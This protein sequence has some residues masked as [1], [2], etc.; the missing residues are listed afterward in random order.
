MEEKK[1][2]ILLVEDNPMDAELNVY[3]LNKFGYNFNSKVVDTKSAYL[4]AIATFEPDIILS[5]YSMPR[6]DGMTSLLIRN[7]TCPFV[8]FIVV[9]GSINEETAVICI[10]A[11]AN[12]YVLKNN[13]KRLGSAVKSALEQS[14]IQKEKALLIEELRVSENFN[15]LLVEYQVDLIS[16]WDLNFDLIFVNDSYSKFHNLPKDKIVGTSW[17]NYVP[18]YSREKAKK[19]YLEIFKDPGI[20]MYEHEVVSP[21]GAIHWFEWTDCPLYDENGLLSGFQSTGRDISYKKFQEKQIQSQLRFINTLL[22]SIPIPVFYKDADLKYTGCNSAYEEFLGISNDDL[23]GKT[24]YEVTDKDLAEIYHKNDLLILQ[25]EKKQT[26][27]AKIKDSKGVLHD[28]IFRKSPLKDSKDKIVG[29]IGAYFDI[30]ERKKMEENLKES[31]EKYRLITDNINDLVWSMDLNLNSVFVSPSFHRILG[32]TVEE[33]QNLPTEKLLTPDSYNK[34]VDKIKETVFKIQKGIIKDKNYTVK[35]EVEQVRK[36]GSIFWAESNVGATYDKKGNVIGIQGVTRDISDRKKAEQALKES[37]EMYRTFLDATEDFAFLK[38]E[39]FKYLIVN[40]SNAD[41]FQKEEKDILGK[42]DYD[43]MHPDAALACKT[44]DQMALDANNMV[45]KEE[46]VNENFFETRKFPVLLKNGKMG[47]GGFIKDMT[48]LKKAE[49]NLIEKEERFRL[50]IENLPIPVGAY[51]INNNLITFFNSRF[52]KVFGYDLNDLKNLNDWFE[53]SFPVKQERNSIIHVWEK[54]INESKNKTKESNS[55]IEISVICKDK[56]VKDVEI[57]FTIDKNTVFIVF[58]DITER[59][60]ILNNLE[61]E[62]SIRTKD[63]ALANN[64]LQLELLE[65]KKQEE[66][67]RYSENLNS[68]TINAINDYI[69]VLD[70]ELKIIMY[71][72]AIKQYLKI[73][74]SDKKAILTNILGKNMQEIF[75]EFDIEIIDKYH[76]I[77]I[78][79]TGFAESIQINRS[80]KTIYFEIKTIPLVSNGKVIQI[81]TSIHDIT[82]LKLAEEEVKYNLQREKELN[83][84]KTRFISVVSHEY[85]TPLA[86]I[87][88]SIQLL[89]RY[90]NK[91]DEEKISSLFAGIYE[92]IRYSNMLL[93]DISIIGKDESGKLEINFTESDLIAISKRCMED[94][95]AIYGNTTNFVFTISQNLK[96]AL[97]DESLLRHVLNNILSNAVKYSEKKKPVNFDVS[98]KD[99]KIIFIIEDKGRGIPENDLKFIYEPFHRASNVD[100]VKGTGLGLTIVKRC[101]ELHNGTIELKS[102]INKGTK[103][104]IKIP[105]NRQNK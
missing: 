48:S 31:E 92:T 101:V 97:I 24:V 10:K 54:A 45:I 70:H 94:I 78:N 63:L 88:S 20:G 14:E 50:M 87:Q 96:Y 32:Y 25:S 71:N 8:P 22:E 1:L 27:E 28:V 34:V 80:G 55:V 33:R 53:V 15:R 29:I 93:D 30:T 38:D 59:K 102:K 85:R 13:L 75:P 19:H 95:K 91:F 104:I 90:R 77:L 46:I 73:I 68:T 18:E 35:I 84:L 60:Q 74:G 36:D 82:K 7:E 67:L 52:S 3:E 40:K 23:I 47:V 49:Q 6:F 51:N 62:I 86:S 98:L 21:S 39:N 4:E 37:E 5:D 64:Q 100:N 57:S 11:G 9:T 103:V 17:L 44:S 89:E 16:R 83:M 69:F 61:R 66:K 58:N 2:K 81:V 76:D 56:T 99:K 12:D 65:R 43:L 26:Y 79:C 42:T 72:D 41:F 105:Y